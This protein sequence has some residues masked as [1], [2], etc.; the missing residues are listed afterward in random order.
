LK[1]DDLIKGD[2]L[3]IDRPVQNMDS[4]FGGRGAQEKKKTEEE[5]PE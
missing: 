1:K 2:P 4:A 5:K 3:R